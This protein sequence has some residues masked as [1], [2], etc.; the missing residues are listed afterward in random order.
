MNLQLRRYGAEFICIYRH[1]LDQRQIGSHCPLLFS[2]QKKGEGGH[3]FEEREALIIDGSL[4]P[5]APRLPDVRQQCLNC[6]RVLMFGSTQTLCE[7]S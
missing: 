7:A 4:R 1:G 6:C 3:V 2:Q 5:T